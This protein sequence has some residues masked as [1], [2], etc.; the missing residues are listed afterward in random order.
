MCRVMKDGLCRT[1]EIT[2]LEQRSA[3]IQ[4]AIVMRKIAARHFNSNPM[5][6][7]NYMAG[8]P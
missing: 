6:G 5:A 8:C 1:F 7:L 2:F 4:I 3:G